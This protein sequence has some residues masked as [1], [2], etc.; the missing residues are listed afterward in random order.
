MDTPY[1]HPRLYAPHM[2]SLEC[3]NKIH[4]WKDARYTHTHT[5]TLCTQLTD[6]RLLHST[7]SYTLAHLSSAL[8]SV[9]WRL[10]RYRQGVGGH[11]PRNMVY[12]VLLEVTE[13][14]TP[15]YMQVPTRRCV[16]R[17]RTVWYLCVRCA[18]PLLARTTKSIFSKSLKPV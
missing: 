11:A 17:S 4:E 18:R 3:P 8:Y 10:L 15:R 2:H 12:L 13:L 6:R 7:N 16:L 5:H 14:F 1:I 9:R